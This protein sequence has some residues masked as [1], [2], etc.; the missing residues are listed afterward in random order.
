VIDLHS[1]LLPGIDDG[2]AHLDEALAMAQIAVADGIHTSVLTP[3]IHPG[4]YDN[5]RSGIEAAV[6]RFDAALKAE[7]IALRVLPGAEVRISPE[8]LALVLQGRVPPIG[9]HRGRPVVL[10]E[11]PH[12]G[13]PVGS[14]QFVQKLLSLNIQPVIAHPERNKALMDDPERI[15]PFVRAGSWLQIT[16]GAVTGHFGPAAQAAAEHYITQGDARWVASDGHN[17][18]ARAPQLSAAHAH[19]QTRWGADFAQRLF[20]THPQQLLEVPA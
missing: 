2:P 13:I 20:H 7:G 4:R 11:L 8:S 17:T 12:S 16:A 14:L 5:E 15:A 6:K 3:H 19:I 18:H 10:L 1:H 9:Q